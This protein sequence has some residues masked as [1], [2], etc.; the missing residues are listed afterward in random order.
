MGLNVNDRARMIATFRYIE[1]R[2][3][4][5]VA[6]WTPTTPEMEVKVVFGRHIWDFAQHADWLGKRTFELRQPEHYTLRPVDSYA[7]LLESMAE[8]D[9]TADRLAALYSVFL[10]AMEE[11]YRSY[12]SATDPLLDQP[13]AVIIDR[14]LVDLERMRGEAETVRKE[15][16]IPAPPLEHLAASERAHQSIVAQRENG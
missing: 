16:S 11:R 6:A 7:A 14:I 3:M 15:L 9:E 8:H 5:I 10:P 13:S 4:E 2:L 12:L 1:V